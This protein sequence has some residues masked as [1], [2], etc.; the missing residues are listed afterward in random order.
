MTAGD[1]RAANGRSTRVMTTDDIVAMRSS[2]KHVMTRAGARRVRG[3][4]KQ[5]RCG[6]GEGGADEVAPLNTS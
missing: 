4:A 6:T 2:T 1:V 5:V 3:H